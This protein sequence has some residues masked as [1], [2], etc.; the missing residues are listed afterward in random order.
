MAVLRRLLSLSLNRTDGGLLAPDPSDRVMKKRRI[1]LE[2]CFLKILDMDLDD[3]SGHLKMDLGFDG[4]SIQSSGI[5][6]SQPHVADLESTI[7]ALSRR[8]RNSIRVY[9][10]HGVSKTG[11]YSEHLRKDIFGDQDDHKRPIIGG[12]EGLSNQWKKIPNSWFE[13][14]SF[15]FSEPAQTPG[16]E[17]FPRIIKFTARFNKI[18]KKICILNHEDGSLTCKSYGLS[19]FTP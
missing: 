18:A 7:R 9:I 1:P 11:S 8:E 13:V 15:A 3:N 10:E 17:A 5:F 14:S 6:Q 19:S 12:Y 4:A 2:L 16:G